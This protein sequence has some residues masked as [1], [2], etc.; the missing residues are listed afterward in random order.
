LEGGKVIWNVK[1]FGVLVQDELQARRNYL[2]G[3]FSDLDGIKVINHTMMAFL[4]E[5]FHPVRAY[6]FSTSHLETPESIGVIFLGEA[7]I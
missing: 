6:D 3:M 2:R 7:H 4:Q 1:D 5:F